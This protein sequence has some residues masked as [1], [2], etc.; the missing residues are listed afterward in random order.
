MAGHVTMTE[1][2]TGAVDLHDLIKINALMDAAEAA[3]EHAHKQKG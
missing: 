1:V 2:N 3:T